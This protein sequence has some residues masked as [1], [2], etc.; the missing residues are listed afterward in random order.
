MVRPRALVD[1][2]A[3]MSLGLAAR[4]RERLAQWTRARTRKPNMV[5]ILV[6]TLVTL[7]V[8]KLP[9]SPKGVL[10]ALFKYAMSILNNKKQWHAD[11]PR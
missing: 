11:I 10:L 3:S 4:K 5:Q 9:L 2:C 6:M 1:C 8:T 7:F